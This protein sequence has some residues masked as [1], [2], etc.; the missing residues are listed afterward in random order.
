VNSVKHGIYLA[1]WECSRQ[2]DQYRQVEA[3]ERTPEKERRG[4]SLPTAKLPG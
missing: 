2:P 3:R 4:R 1:K